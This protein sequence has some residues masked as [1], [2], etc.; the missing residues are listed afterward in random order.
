ME[1]ILSAGSWPGWM[2]RPASWLRGLGTARTAA[3]L[4]VE[5]RLSLGVKK[6][7]VLVNCRGRQV[8]LALSGDSV[9]PILELGE[10]RKPRG[11]G[12]RR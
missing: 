1:Q 5:A 11:K 10:T 12:A 4:R 3:P 6:S 9:S 7:L 2:A 8:L